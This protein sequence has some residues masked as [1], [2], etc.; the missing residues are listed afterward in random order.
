MSRK[1]NDLDPRF[2]PI[3]VEFLARCAEARIPVVIIFTGRTPAEQV[4]LLRKKVSWTRNSRHLPQ[5]PFGKAL[6]I[7]VAPYEQYSLHGPDKLNF[8]AKDPIWRRL[9]NIGEGLGLRWGGRW[10]KRDMGHF[11]MP[12]RNFKAEQGPQGT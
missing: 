4:E 12:I 7:D 8:D 10:R 3:A 2:R 5:H 1:L 9:G 6:A 11:E